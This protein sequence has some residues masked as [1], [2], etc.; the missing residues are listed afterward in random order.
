MPVRHRVA[1][2]ALA[3]G[4]AA[5]RLGSG[6]AAGL[7]P[8][9]G[10]RRRAGPAVGARRRHPGGAGPPPRPPTRAGPQGLGGGRLPGRPRAGRLGQLDRP[11]RAARPAGRGA[12]AGEPGG[13]LYLVCAHGRHDPAA[14]SAAGRSPRRWRRPAPAR[15]GSARTSAATGS[16]RTSS[17]CRTASSTRTSPPGPRRRSRPRTSAGEVR[18]DLL[19]GRSAFAPPAQAAQHYAR[20]ELGETGWTRCGRWAWP[21][22]A[23]HTWR[24]RLADPPRPAAGHRPG[25]ARRRRCG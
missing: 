1:D 6:G 15:S 12:G 22:L 18:P 25:R 3:A 24:V 9:P 16:P 13:P 19:R 17:R 23:E 14:R 20:L 2:P 11:G 4:R 8:R 7:E 10:G 21:A 5:R